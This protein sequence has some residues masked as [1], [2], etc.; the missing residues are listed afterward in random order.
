MP[1][2]RREQRRGEGRGDGGSGKGGSGGSFYLIFFRSTGSLI[3]RAALRF[4]QNYSAPTARVHRTIP[5]WHVLYIYRPSNT[6]FFPRT[7]NIIIMLKLKTCIGQLFIVPRRRDG[8]IKSVR[9]IED[10]R[11]NEVYIKF[12]NVR[13]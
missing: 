1:R 10:M 4:S 3:H 6:F 2:S 5:T 13:T 7:P 11:T 8:M 12:G 9:M